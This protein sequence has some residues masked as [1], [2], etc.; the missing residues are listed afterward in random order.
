[1][2]I[3]TKTGDS[4]ETGLFGGPRVGKDAPR[5]AAY[6]DIDELNAVIGLAR[7]LLPPREID[8][9]LERVQHHLFD[10]G[11]ELATPDPAKHGTHLLGP[12]EI[13]ALEEAIDEMEGTLPPLRQF[14]LP[15]GAPIAAQL[16]V[17]RC[18]CRRA[19]R[20]IVALSH[21]D[22]VSATV[23]MYI[24]RLSDFLFVMARFANQGSGTAD[25]PWTKADRGE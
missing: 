10:L 14:I 17:A 3:Y 21:I 1:M 16:H 19:E 15:G 23:L 20:S 25:V 11:A 7:S 24:N 13:A 22:A 12:A 4:G 5:I 9:L 18:V 2:K 6:G 8:A